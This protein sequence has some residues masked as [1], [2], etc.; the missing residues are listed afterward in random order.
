MATALPE[1][2][3]AIVPRDALY[4]D[5]YREAAEAMRSPKMR[6]EP[7]F[8]V[9]EHFRGK[10]MTSLYAGD[11][12]T[13]RRAMSAL[14]RG[15]EIDRFRDQIT[16]PAL[17]RQLSALAN[18]GG[19]SVRTDLYQLLRRTFIETAAA[20]VGLHQGE[21]GDA[22][23]QDLIQQIDAISL[24]SDAK[25]RP[26]DWRPALEKGLAG[27]EE[28]RQSFYEPARARCPYAPG[29]PP[30]AG[31]VSLVGL[32]AAAVDP[33]WHDPEAA[34]HESINMLQAS[35]GT[36]TQ[37]LTH[38]VN[39][40]LSWLEDNPG[41][42]DRTGDLEFLSLVVQEA[43]R[44]H[45]PLPYQ[46]RVAAETW[47]LASGTEIAKDHWVVQVPKVTNR[48]RSV[49][50]EDADRFDPLREIEPGIPRYG[51]AFGAG[52]H[53]CIGLRFILGVDGIGAHAHVLRRLFSAGLK[54]D[55]ERPAH[56]A[57]GTTIDF[58]DRYPIVLSRS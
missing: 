16:L 11:H 40:L 6:P 58:F 36:A 2:V 7:T 41:A 37:M 13:R 30:G 1:S 46:A 45:P 33:D 17:E 42:V 10:S 25:W 54:R 27:K 38:A 47:T 51:L 23:A 50:G 52:Q 34:L 29:R 56:H 53:Q 4:L 39:D 22:A 31:D 49:F 28:F 9:Q 14:V 15:E 24:A 44:L 57:E 32:I 19:Q 55:P 43:L 48:D 3:P 5:G 21:L 20:V 12:L 26:G 8:H 18:A 35:I